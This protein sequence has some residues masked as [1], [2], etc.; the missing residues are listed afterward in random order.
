MFENRNKPECIRCKS[1]GDLGMFHK[2]EVDVTFRAL[3]VTLVEPTAG[4]IESTDGCRIFIFCI[5]LASVFGLILE[6]FG[7]V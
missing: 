2:L 4:F 3:G 1:P 6:P 5:W 7:L